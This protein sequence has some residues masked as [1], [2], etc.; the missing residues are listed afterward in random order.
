LKLPEV[1]RNLTGFFS[2]KYHELMENNFKKF[3][4]S[5]TGKGNLKLSSSQ[6]W[7]LLHPSPFD[8]IWNYFYLLSKDGEYNT[9][10]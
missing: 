10:R 3:I 1:S 5:Y 2:D 8:S 7:Y 4:S 9:L 6:N